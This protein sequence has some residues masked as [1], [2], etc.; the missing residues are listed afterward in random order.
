MRLGGSQ[1]DDAKPLAAANL[2]VRG[3]VWLYTLGLPLETRHGRRSEID[4]DLWDQAHAWDA[5]RPTT[6]GGYSSVLL[7]CLRG[8]PADLLWR[9]GEA[10]THPSSTEGRT[11][12]QTFT[13]RSSLGRATIILMAGL[14][15]ATIAFSVVHTVEYNNPGTRFLEPWLKIVLGALLLSVGLVLTSSGFG[16]MR[17][18]PWLGA[19][20]AVGGTW[21]VASIFYWLWL[22]PL[23]VAA[24]VSV[25][26]I[27]WAKRRT[28]VDTRERV[29]NE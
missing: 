26:A 25:F 3:W 9:F 5:Q 2:L 11:A 14:V 8:S 15:G 29:K 24:G 28:D 18:A 7:R 6:P 1:Q 20:L 27:A 22:V 21:M 12:R 17:R 4:S 10:R 13:M 16:L 19:V 23:F